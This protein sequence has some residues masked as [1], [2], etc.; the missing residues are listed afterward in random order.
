MLSG[1]IRLLRT[2]ITIAVGARCRKEDRIDV[3]KEEI[4]ADLV[5]ELMMN[6]EVNGI[7][8]CELIDKQ[9]I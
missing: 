6:G 3:T 8:L 7:K 4:L 2:S 5:N 9:H 1:E